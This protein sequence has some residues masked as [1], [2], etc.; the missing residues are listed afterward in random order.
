MTDSTVVSMLMIEF[1]HCEAGLFSRIKCGKEVLYACEPPSI[2]I[3]PNEHCIDGGNYNVIAF[4]TSADDRDWLVLGTDAEEMPQIAPPRHY[5]NGTPHIYIGTG[6]GCYEGDWCVTG[7]T[8]GS[9]RFHNW[10]TDID[11]FNLYIQRYTAPMQG[12]PKQQT[13]IV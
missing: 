10:L 13:L 2:E 11:N 1:A 7:I 3:S 6:L 9:I 8:E 4:D 5:I 12:E